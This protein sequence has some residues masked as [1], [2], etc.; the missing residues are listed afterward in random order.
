M[1]QAA[2]PALR[3]PKFSQ[4]SPCPAQGHSQPLILPESLRQGH[5]VKRNKQVENSYCTRKVRWPETFQPPQGQMRDI[6]PSLAVLSLAV[7]AF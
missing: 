6:Y 7:R 2:V 3:P 1:A 5:W 4:D